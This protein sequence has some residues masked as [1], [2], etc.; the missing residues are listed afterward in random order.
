MSSTPLRQTAYLIDILNSARAIQEYLV[1]YDR[2]RF[3]HD[4]R[5][6]DAVLRRLLIIGEACARLTSDTRTEL[7]G[8][9]FGKIVGLRN[10]VV[11]DYGQ[12]D[13]QIIWD[14]VDQ[15]VSSLIEQL[16]NF[17][18]PFDSPS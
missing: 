16:H 5:T 8:I 4:G 1:G 18:G 2:D 10:H 6:Q 7:P 13:L 14:V 17:L 15:H 11:H 3:L 9:P 12:V